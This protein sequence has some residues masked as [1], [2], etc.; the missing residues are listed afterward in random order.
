MISVNGHRTF[1]SLNE[2]QLFHKRG[3][4]N[5]KKNICRLA[6]TCMAQRNIPVGS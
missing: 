5:Y 4:L 2:L 1:S 6:V 3:K